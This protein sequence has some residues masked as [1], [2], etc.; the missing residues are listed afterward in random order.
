VKVE[1]SLNLDEFKE[2]LTNC[3]GFKEL[4]AINNVKPATETVKNDGSD[5]GDE[6]SAIK[7]GP[8]AKVTLEEVRAKLAALS[9]DGKQA[10]VKALI[11]KY[12][13]AKLSD[14]TKDKYPSLLKDAEEL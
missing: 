11:K 3:D 14:I 5:K 12:G 10:E 4:L 13:G 7:S 6:P 1:I 9:Q 2:L 8:Q